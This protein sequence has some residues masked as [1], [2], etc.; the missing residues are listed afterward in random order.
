MRPEPTLHVAED[1][2]RYVASTGTTTRQ[3]HY[4]SVKT[5]TTY[6]IDESTGKVVTTYKSKQMPGVVVVDKPAYQPAPLKDAPAKAA[7]AKEGCG[8]GAEIEE[9]E[10]TTEIEE[11]EGCEEAEDADEPDEDEKGDG[12]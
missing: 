12:K 10:E 9:V 8:C 1:D 11:V 2:P 3:V 6:V 5:D 4:Y 7:P